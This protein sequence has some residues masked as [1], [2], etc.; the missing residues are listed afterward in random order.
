[1][2]LEFLLIVKQTNKLF[3]SS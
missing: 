2:K 3:L 1:M